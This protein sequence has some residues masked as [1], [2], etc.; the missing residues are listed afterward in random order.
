MSAIGAILIA[1]GTT[2][3]VVYLASRKARAAK[4]N[5]HPKSGD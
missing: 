1:T 5:E 2:G 3:L 4:P